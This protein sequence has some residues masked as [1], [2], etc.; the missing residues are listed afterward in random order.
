MSAVLAGRRSPLRWSTARP[1]NRWEGLSQQV[2]G[3]TDNLHHLRC[4]SAH[5]ARLKSSRVFQCST[6]LYVNESYLYVA[7]VLYAVSVQRIPRE[8]NDGG[9]DV[10]DNDVIQP[11]AIP[12]PRAENVRRNSANLRY[13]KQAD[14]CCVRQRR[15]IHPTDA[16]IVSGSSKWLRWNKQRASRDC[17]E[18][19]RHVS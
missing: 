15:P 16:R 1:S 2:K 7:H 8:F 18:H 5:L 17:E 13:K 4:R 19:V 12:D 14:W 6:S 11:S 10:I 9:I 3:D